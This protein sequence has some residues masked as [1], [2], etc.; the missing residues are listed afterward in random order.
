MKRGW[1]MTSRCTKAG[2]GLVGGVVL[3]ALCSGSVL[4]QAKQF[5]DQ[6]LACLMNYAWTMT[7]PKFTAPDGKVIVVD[8]T[9]KTEV[10]IPVDVAREVT[11]VARVSAYAEICHLP[12]EQTANYRT[13][14]R[15]EEAKK[16][17]TDQQLLFINQLHLVTLMVLTG[18]F[19]RVDK[20]TG[21]KSKPGEPIELCD[22]VMLKP[23]PATQVS[24]CSDGEKD[25]LR[26][27]IKAYIEAA[28]AA[29]KTAEPVK[30]GTQK[31]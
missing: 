20:D 12:E 25:K 21:A 24:T 27:H 14:M 16:A 5:S 26:A 10:V 1:S 18:R 30:A 6:S 13:M 4:A 31:K 7:P 3:A 11:R 9:K 15:R 23:K 22:G 2:V 28:P 8:K 29:S 17:W 19:E